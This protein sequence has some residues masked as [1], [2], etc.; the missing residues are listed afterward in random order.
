MYVEE[1][2]NN[3]FIESQLF[4]TLLLNEFYQDKDTIFTTWLVGMVS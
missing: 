1:V 4:F 2:F 3:E